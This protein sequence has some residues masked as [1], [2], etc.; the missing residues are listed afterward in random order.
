MLAISICVFSIAAEC[1][2]VEKEV[3]QPNRVIHRQADQTAE[4]QIW[5]RPRTLA[6]TLHFRRPIESVPLLLVDARCQQ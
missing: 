6:E 4:A 3:D 5:S 1:E 2:P